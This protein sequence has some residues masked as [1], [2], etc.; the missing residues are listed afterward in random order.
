MSCHNECRRLEDAC[1]ECI[2]AYFQR[3]IDSEAQREADKAKPATVAEWRDR[4][5]L[6][7]PIVRP[8]TSGEN[9]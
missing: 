9:P 5:D 4:L 7:A 1:V 3:Y 6:I 2:E 8:L